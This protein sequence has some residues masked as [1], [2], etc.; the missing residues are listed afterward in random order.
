NGTWSITGIDVT[1]LGDGTITYT[2]TASTSGGTATN[3]KTA[4]KDT[5]APA[6]N[7]TTV[8]T[9]INGGNFSNASASGTGEVGATISVPVT[10]GTNTTPAVTTTV[11]SGGTWS[12]T[13]LNLSNLKDGTVSYTARATDAAGN[14]ASSTSP[15]QKSALSVDMTTVTAI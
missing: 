11:G 13:G 4:S 7:V 14:T 9:P 12:V 1:S 6:V 5:T 8:T 3:T 10:D 15:G 2:A